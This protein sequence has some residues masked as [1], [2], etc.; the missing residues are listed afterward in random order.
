MSAVSANP[1]SKHFRQP[2]LYV[3]LPSQGKYWQE[4]SIE[5][6][7]SNEIPVYPMTAKDEIIIRT[8][9]ALLN[10]ESVI[11]VI[12]NC[13]PNIKN[14]W[15]MP[16]IDVDA[17]LIAIRIASY[18]ADLPIDTIC[19]HC[20]HSNRHEIELPAILE[21]IKSPD[22]NKLVTIGD[23]K[24][25]LKPQSYYESN[26]K[27][28][29]LF[30]EERILQTVNNE[31]IDDEKKVKQFNAHLTKL[32]DLN[33][34]IVASSVEYIEL[35]DSTKVTNEKFIHEYFENCENAVFKQL[36]SALEN[37]NKAVEL[38]TLTLKCEECDKDYKSKMEFDYANFFAVSY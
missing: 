18:G 31:E 30:E 20:N 14:A 6:P 37:I 11:Q 2:A 7:I 1:L 23:L 28:L 33:L 8:P 29:V 26:R 12:Q 9:D 36:L 25:K 38:P 5:M 17:M 21:T 16:T 32:V 19:T 24:I 15:K 13:C 10:G 4:D 22:Y 35:P 34:D 27:R 3:K